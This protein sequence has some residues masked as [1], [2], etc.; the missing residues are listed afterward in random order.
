MASGA[1]SAKCI[2][3]TR[4]WSNVVGSDLNDVFHQASYGYFGTSGCN[5]SAEENSRCA[6][7]YNAWN[8]ATVINVIADHGA[9]RC[10]SV[11]CDCR[12]DSF[13]DHGAG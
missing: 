3:G 10:H 7:Q 11:V 6:A 12:S 8:G 2:R 4:F 13:N 1:K 9:R 5:A